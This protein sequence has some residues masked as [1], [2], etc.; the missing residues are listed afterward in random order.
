MHPDILMIPNK[1]LRLKAPPII[2]F[3]YDMLFT[4]SNSMHR[5]LEHYK[6]VG[7]ACTQLGLP[8]RMFVA[9]VN[10]QIFTVCNP[11]I[12]AYSHNISYISKEGCLSVP[13]YWDTVQ[14]RPTVQL[15]YQDITG[16]NQ[17]QILVKY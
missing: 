17:M 11:K 7:L 4:L 1:K 3:D 2:E 14:R 13:G 8:I 12:S 6:G 9:K 15:E 16:K 5:A 10:G